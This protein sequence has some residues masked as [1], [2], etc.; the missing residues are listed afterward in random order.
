MQENP[1]YGTSGKKYKNRVRAF[2]LEDTTLV[3]YWKEMGFILCSQS[4]NMTVYWSVL[5][6]IAHIIFKE[7][8]S[9]LLDKCY[10]TQFMP[11]LYI[12]FIEELSEKMF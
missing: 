1:F 2:T 9:E 10:V 6:N 4:S 7:F 5:T 8:K 12:T 3:F 11:W